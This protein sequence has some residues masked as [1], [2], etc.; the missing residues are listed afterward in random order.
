MFNDDQALV[1]QIG[2]QN[3]PQIESQKVFGD[4]AKNK[5]ISDQSL[6]ISIYIYTVYIYMYVSI[7]TYISI[8]YIYIYNMNV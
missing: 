7:Y 4:L 2:P 1:L 6:Y 5:N 8:Y 3:Q